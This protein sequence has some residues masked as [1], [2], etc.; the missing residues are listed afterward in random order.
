MEQKE[1]KE[2]LKGLFTLMALVVTELK[3][4][5]QLQD[6]MMILAKIKS[7]PEIQAKLLEA[8]K[9]INAVPAELKT[10]D[11]VDVFAI[12]QDVAPDFLNLLK[13]FAKA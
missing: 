2:A 11:V 8:Y 1:L 10:I 5:A 4:G 12:L 3:D 6:A 7:S 13:S 9:G